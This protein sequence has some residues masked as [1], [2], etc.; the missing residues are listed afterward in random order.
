[1]VPSHVQHWEL[2]LPPPFTGLKGCL[3]AAG[4]PSVLVSILL[5]KRY[6]EQGNSSKIS[7][8]TGGAFLQFWRLSLLSS[9]QVAWQQAGTVL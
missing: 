2:C 5:L 7:H 6:H 3:P 8:F 1:M 9:W 4:M